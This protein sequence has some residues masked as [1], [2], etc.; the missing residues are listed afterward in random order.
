MHFFL[1]LD[2]ALIWGDLYR[3]YIP[4]RRITHRPGRP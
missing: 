2:V 3:G 1:R 4:L